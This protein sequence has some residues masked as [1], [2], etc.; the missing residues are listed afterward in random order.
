MNW[1]SFKSVL[2]MDRGILTRLLDFARRRSN[3]DYSYLPKELSSPG[4]F[5]RHHPIFEE[6]RPYSGMESGGYEVD[7]VGTKTA[8]KHLHPDAI[9]NI[10]EVKTEIPSVSEEYFEWIDALMSV[11][12][13]RK[14]YTAVELGAGYGRWG[15][16]CGLAARDRGVPKIKLIF[17]EP[18]PAHLVW[19]KEHVAEN[20]FRG[21]EVQLIDGAVSNEDGTVGFYVGL[22]DSF[23]EDT[24]RQW[25]GQAIA[26]SYEQTVDDENNQSTAPETYF[27]MPVTRYKSGYVTVEVKKFNIKR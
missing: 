22:P 25:F 1:G 17:A 20:G 24:P 23:D 12:S 10:G 9:G 6:F 8:L 7:F 21:D 2:T 3:V 26:Q 16:R 5:R 13:A 4:P 18:E 14:S 19:L 11:R 27:G 15:V